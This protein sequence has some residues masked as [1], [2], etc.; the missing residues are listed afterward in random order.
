[1]AP[2]LRR[3]REIAEARRGGYSLKAL[4]MLADAEFEAGQLRAAFGDYVRIARTY[5]DAEVA[6]TAEIRAAQLSQWLEGADRAA[7]RFA[8]IGEH[9]ADKPMVAPL[10]RFYEA[11]AYEAS[12]RWQDAV[13]AYRTSLRGWPAR[14]NDWIGVE[15]KVMYFSDVYANSLWPRYIE[16]SKV[17]DRIDQL[18]E[19]A[20]DRTEGE[21][22]RAIWLLDHERPAEARQLIRRLERRSSQQ[23]SSTAI[24]STR[25]RAD[26]AAAVLQ[27][28]PDGSLTPTAQDVLRK[29]CD[30]PFDP[31]V[32]VGC[33]I[34]ASISA[35]DGQGGA[36]KALL[37]RTLEAW[38]HWQRD[39]RAAQPSNVERDVM[40]IRDAVVRSSQARMA[41]AARAT[42]PP[43]VFMLASVDVSLDHGAFWSSLNLP[44]PRDQ[45]NA[46][47]LSQTEAQMIWRTVERL[48]TCDPGARSTKLTELWESLLG[49]SASPCT[50]GG[51]WYSEPVIGTV[52]FMDPERSRAHA[53]V[54][55]GNGGTEAVAEML[56]GRWTITR[57][58][59]V[60]VY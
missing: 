27:V 12:A 49:F 3:L 57:N 30:E 25:H 33:A 47:V 29:T 13:A 23:A 51:A 28:S 31:W 4:V 35:A 10:A 5:P 15:W 54:L 14:D 40:A 36:A 11:R 39:M 43:F 45:T 37:L 24:R 50:A 44:A 60:W 2:A 32:G 9:Y 6:W 16:R 21:V 19:A 26:V 22:A 46:V 48:A 41:A 59:S 34:A 7:A 38:V 58:A 17:A 53:I 8:L 55:E 18:R 42:Q 52:H 56:G 20:A 1:M